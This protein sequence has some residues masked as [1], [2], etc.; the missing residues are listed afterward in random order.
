MTMLSLF[1]LGNMSIPAPQNIPA[2]VNA[3]ISQIVSTDDLSK[4][5]HLLEEADEQTLVLLDV[6]Q[7]LLTP[8]DPILKPKWDKLL[9]QWLGGKK[10]I[11]DASGNTRYI[12]RELLMRAPHSLIDPQS[13]ALVQRLQSKSVPV[14]AFSA[15]VGGKIG[16]VESFIDWRIDE[17]RRFGFDF[18]SAFPNLQPLQ[19]PKDPHMEC[20]PVY[21]S[22]VLL[23]SLHDKGDVLRNFLKEIHWTPQKVIFID[24]QLS[25]VQSVA[26][27]LEGLIPT[28]GIHYTGASPLPCELEEQ[29]AKQ[30]VDHFLN[31]GEWVSQTN[32]S[33]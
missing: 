26:A 21:K 13:P 31:T 5:E 25:N 2:S 19:L 33:H 11:V 18:Q 30:Q 29:T 10:F 14:I 4:I 23:T 32:P 15:A 20:P 22:G 7:T 9:D 16:N 12:F 1:I 27:S 6:D 8:D 17:L 28:I 3:S 24:D